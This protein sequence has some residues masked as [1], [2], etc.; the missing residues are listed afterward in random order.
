MNYKLKALLTPA[1]WVTVGTYNK[2]YDKWLNTQIDNQIPFTNISD[3]TASL[4]GQTLWI[5]N[6]PYSSFG[7]YNDPIKCA[8]AQL[9]AK[10]STMLK[11]M[12]W[13]N[14]CREFNQIESM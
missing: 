2:Q 3:Y 5:V 14:V 4:N 10:R 6:H 11:A 1:C 7:T 13:L 9:I 8:S 12:D